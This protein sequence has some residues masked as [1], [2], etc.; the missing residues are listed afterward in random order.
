VIA[1]EQVHERT[2]TVAALGSANVSAARMLAPN[3]VMGF[4]FSFSRVGA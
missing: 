1:S 4:F 3:A 2:I